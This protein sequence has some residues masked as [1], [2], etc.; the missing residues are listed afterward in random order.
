MQR[1]SAKCNSGQTH[2]S[3]QHIQKDRQLRRSLRNSIRCLDQAAGAAA[4]RFLR[5][6]SRPNAPRPVAKSGR[7]AGSGV[8]VKLNVVLKLSSTPCD[9]KRAQFRSQT[10]ADPGAIEVTRAPLTCAKGSAEL[11][12]PDDT[13][14]EFSE[15]HESIIGVVPR[16]RRAG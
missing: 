10:N 2:R 16:P 15:P 12:T 13:V 1:L 4:F 5:Q 9:P 14:K 3:K 6:P 11:L 7:A 8:G